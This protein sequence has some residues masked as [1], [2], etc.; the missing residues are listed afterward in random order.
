VSRRGYLDWLRGV[1]V[2]IMIEAHTV[3]SWTR[4]DH[5]ST[6]AYGWAVIIA[7]FGA[8]IFLFLAGVALALAAGARV[9]KGQSLEAAAAAA[10]RRGWQIFGL[11][12]VFRLQ[13]WLI[14]GGP[15]TSLMKVDI[16]NVMGVSML[17][18][19]LLWGWGRS[20][21]SRIAW[22]AAAAVVFTMVTPILREARLFAA[23]PD[24]LEGYIRPV[25]RLNTFSLFP[26]AGF[27]FAGGAVGAWL[28]GVQTQAAERRSQVMFA[29][30]GALL[31]LG[32]L[33]ATHLPPIYAETSF[34]TSSPT[35]FFLRVGILVAALPLAFAWN[36]LWHG[37]SP[38]QEFGRASLFVYWIHVEMVYGV[39]S[40]AIHKQLTF[41]Q[42]LIAFATFSLFLFAL[43]K[44]VDGAKR[45]RFGTGAGKVPLRP[46]RVETR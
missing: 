12:F 6:A 4:L 21:W 2:L 18:G 3:D 24:R 39:V 33:A 1:A 40:A 36:A 43:V 8:P 34:W 14:S 45:G 38:L 13:S 41:G 31:A 19:A 35:F 29:V 26:W 25:G 30:V 10:R 22:F 23:W 11:A 37:Y 27:L 5:R 16:L 42:A 9:R 15:V 28:E 46:A 17:I 7:G 44:L 32:G 20:R